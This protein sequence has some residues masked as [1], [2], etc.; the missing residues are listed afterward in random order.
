MKFLTLVAASCLSFAAVAHHG[1][2]WAEEE[3]SELIGK[4]AAISMSP[5]HPTLRV[6]AEDGMWQVDLG[7]PTQ[8]ARSGFMEELAKVGDDIVVLGNRSLEKDKKHMKAVRITVRGKN[9]DM[10]PERLRKN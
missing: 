1:W 7:N 5:P 9:F 3:Q 8:T 2:S 6:Q 10:Y 4:I